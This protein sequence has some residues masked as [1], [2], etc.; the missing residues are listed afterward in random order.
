MKIAIINDTHCGI[1]NGSDVF[2]DNAES[3]YKNVFFP[4]LDEQ[5][6]T[7]ILHLGKIILTA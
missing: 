4:Y 1:K 7:S 2:L 3:F 6:I 5:N